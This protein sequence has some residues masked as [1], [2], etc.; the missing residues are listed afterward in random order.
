MLYITEV[1]GILV[2]IIVSSDHCFVQI[3]SLDILYQ[4]IDGYKAD[5]ILRLLSTKLLTRKKILY[6]TKSLPELLLELFVIHFCNMSSSTD[7]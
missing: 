7:K 3:I 6:L 2:Y 4:L 5:N 1:I